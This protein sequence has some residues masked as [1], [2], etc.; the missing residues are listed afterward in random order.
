MTVR[1]CCHNKNLD[2][3]QIRFR[4]T[5]FQIWKLKVNAKAYEIQF[6]WKFSSVKLSEVIKYDSK[7][8]WTFEQRR[9]KR[10]TL[11][12]GAVY[13]IAILLADGAFSNVLVKKFEALVVPGG[14]VGEENVE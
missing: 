6:N 1:D 14:T 13:N 3:I 2:Q 7:S 10:S 9:C 12:S 8:D 11:V 4:S 5:K